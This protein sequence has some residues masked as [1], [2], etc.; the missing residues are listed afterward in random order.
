LVQP[1][2]IIKSKT[3]DKEGYRFVS[4][5]PDGELETE[6]DIYSRRY[7]IKKDVN[8]PHAEKKKKK[9]KPEKKEEKKPSAY[10]TTRDWLKNKWKDRD[11]C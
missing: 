3:D 6:D 1:Q 8:K 7:K 4:K 5:G 11:G 2:L 10:E 9:K